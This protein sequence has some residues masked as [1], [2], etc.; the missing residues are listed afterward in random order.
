MRVLHGILS[1]LMLLLT[2]GMV[3]VL[4]K[5]LLL[6]YELHHV[7]HLVTSG[8]MLVLFGYF[9]WAEGRRAFR[10][11]AEVNDNFTSGGQDSPVQTVGTTLLESGP[12]MLTVRPAP[13]SRLTNI[14]LYIFWLIIMVLFVPGQWHRHLWVA[15]TLNTLLGLLAIL[16]LTF[17][18]LHWK[19][20]AVWDRARGQ[21][22]RNG[23]A[24]MPLTE[25]TNVENEKVGGVHHVVLVTTGGVRLRATQAL[26]AYGKPEDA[27]RVAASVKQFLGLTPPA[28]WPPP[29]TVPGGEGSGRD[30]SIMLPQNTEH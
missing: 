6:P 22:L 30:E 7:S 12:D 23:A 16:M 25:I 5:H 26:T 15:V 18:A 11:P 27:A 14:G 2:L 1:G 17:T 3:S 8:L 9:M 10:G 13:K 4:R 29:P 21:F 28:V 24:V 19:D 20:R